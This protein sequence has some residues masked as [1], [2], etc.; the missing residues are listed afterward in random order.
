MDKP[1]KRK[2]CGNCPGTI[3]YGHLFTVKDRQEIPLPSLGL[4]D[5]CGAIA[6]DGSE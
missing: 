5:T 2:K 4:C 6:Y 3:N 1:K